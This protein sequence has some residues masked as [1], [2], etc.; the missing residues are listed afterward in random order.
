MYND[1]LQNNQPIGFTPT[2]LGSIS[3]ENLYFVE[4]NQS[5][6]PMTRRCYMI[7][8]LNSETINNIEET[9]N[10]ERQLS[11][12]ITAESLASNLCGI[13]GL[14]G[15]VQGQ[16]AIDM[17]NGWKT[18]R[19]RVI[20]IVVVRAGP[21][22][23]K[24][25]I[26]GYTDYIG[27]TGNDVLDPNMT[28][29]INSITEV[30]SI[31]NVKTKTYNLHMGETYSTLS[32]FCN[33]GS[34][35]PQPTDQALIRPVDMMK[36]NLALHTSQDEYGE[37]P[38]E[39]SYDNSYN[40]LG[41][42]EYPTEGTETSVRRNLDPSIYLSRMVNGYIAGQHLSSIDYDQNT[43]T[44]ILRSAMRGL[45][46]PEFLN[47]SFIVRL[48]EV[49]NNFSPSSLSLQHL[50]ALDT[51]L[52]YDRT[53]R[54]KILRNDTVPT[55]EKIS[56]EVR[57]LDAPV[58]YTSSTIA[59]TDRNLRVLEL[60][61]M[62]TGHLLNSCLTRATIFISAIIPGQPYVTIQDAD[63]L[64]GQDILLSAC[65][66]FKTVMNSMVIP[67][68]T[69][70]YVNPCEIMI[71]SDVLKDTTIVLTEFTGYSSQGEREIFRFPTFADSL[72]NPMIATTSE[73]S[74]L[75]RDLNE[76]F[77]NVL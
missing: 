61:N 29:Y 57:D 26:Q 37:Y 62:I 15:N 1:E 36:I 13:V 74:T 11:G 60:N 45:P 3:I 18:S 51:D 20:L 63:S 48:R 2:R 4:V 71:Q 44:D 21:L 47:N 22:Y 38:T 53:G 32:D 68:F 49:T 39:N 67:Y 52:M 46:E 56:N 73:R 8:N 34:V 16:R 64:L 54:I 9:F 70:N 75:N 28:I 42:G 35:Y 31:Y 30:K 66:N 24:Y 33:K 77:N 27:V 10:R 69:R 40:V 19:F 12:K 43:R 41:F 72:W 6:M 59:P 58:D 65:E 76:I 55:Y 17:P 7:N 23:T 14:R 50:F 25:F 5:Y